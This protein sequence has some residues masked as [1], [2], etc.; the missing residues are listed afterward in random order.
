MNRLTAL[1]KREIVVCDLKARLMPVTAMQSCAGKVTGDVEDKETIRFFII[2]FKRPHA[3]ALSRSLPLLVVQE[4]IRI[5]D[6]HV[7]AYILVSSTIF[8]RCRRQCR[9]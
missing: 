3:E 7:T 2:F 9:R 8:T 5:C 4:S 6:A 1:S